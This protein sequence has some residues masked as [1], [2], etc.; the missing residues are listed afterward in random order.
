MLGFDTRRTHRGAVNNAAAGRARVRNDRAARHVSFNDLMTSI[1]APSRLFAPVTTHPARRGLIIGFASTLIAGLVLTIAASVAI[2]IAAANSILPGISIEGVALGG[3]DRA[4]ALE[5]L[6]AG[7]PSLSSGQATIEVDGERAVVAYEDVGRR[8]DLDAMVDA[9]FRVGRDTNPLA[10]GV[11]RLRNLVHP[12]ALPVVVHAFDPDALHEAAA[13][14]AGRFS[15]EAVD[16]AVTRDGV[17]FTVT[18]SAS[19]R[20]LEADQV[21]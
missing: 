17:T 20:I 18:P 3:L 2:G 14:V 8:H 11:A 15:V 5:R 7:L 16:A 6:A 12:A 1:T 21:Q 9:A 4:S 19:G 13:E 10:G